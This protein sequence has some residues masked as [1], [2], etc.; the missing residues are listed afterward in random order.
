MPPRLRFAPS[1]SG[2]L[3]IGGARTALFNWLYARHTGGTFVVRI[4]DTDQERSSRESVEAILEGL[5]WLGLNWDEGPGV[6]GPYAPYAQSERLASYRERV[7]WLIAHG[8]AYRDYTTEA[9]TRAQ[10][11][12]FAA[13]VGL[14]PKDD[15]RRAGFKFKSAWRDKIGNTAL[16][17]IVR[18]RIQAKEDSVGFEDLVVGR[19]EKAMLDL[20]DFVLLRNDGFPLYNLA[21]VVDDHGMEISHVVRGQEHLNSTLPQLLLYRAFGWE[22]PAFAHLPLILGPD[23]EK[24]SKRRH[25]EADV[26]LHRQNGVAPQALLNFLVRIGWS[27]H[28]KE[29]FTRK[30][31]IDAFDF[32]AV[33]R[34]NGVW[35]TEKLASL[36]QHWMKALPPEELLPS[37]RAFLEQ[38]RE[39]SRRRDPLPLRDEALVIGIRALAPRAKSLV[40]I[41]ST[42]V[43][44]FSRGVAISE[45][46]R[47]KHLGPEG[48]AALRETEAALAASPA[49]EPELLEGVV[50]TV[51]SGS[52]RKKGGIAQ[53]LRVAVTGGTVSPGIGDTLAILGRGEALRRIREAMDNRA[54]P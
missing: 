44:Y 9:E 33:G 48:I 40:E 24:L 49:W 13:S 39:E 43:A 23:R 30:E 1:P 6:G 47:A 28:D 2:Y 54:A 21:C 22:V 5:R 14:G 4:E 12:A 34:A 32:G 11:V 46:A 51:A 17:H 8:H 37:V 25:P 18:F 31:M 15:L 27:Q 10:R 36:N 3:H 16:P 35:N 20:D 19:V 53:P 45:E 7:D 41:A 52:K 26:M 42:L 29:I 50:E 38:R